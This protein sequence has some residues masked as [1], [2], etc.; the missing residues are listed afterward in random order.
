M[1]IEKR[2]NM[3]SCSHKIKASLI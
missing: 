1:N 3:N 2:K